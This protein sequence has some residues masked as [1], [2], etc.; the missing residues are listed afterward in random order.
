M[1]KDT[2]RKELTQQLQAAG[3]VDYSD[4]VE[5]SAL[6]QR[7]RKQTAWLEVK[8]LIIDRLDE[9]PESILGVF[10]SFDY[11]ILASA[12]VRNR[13]GE[14]QSGDEK[15]IMKHFPEEEINN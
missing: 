8:R 9:D 12:M 10:N 1:D 7:Q 3:H 2:L 14:I 4:Q 11:S 13:L 6:F 15:L 5:K